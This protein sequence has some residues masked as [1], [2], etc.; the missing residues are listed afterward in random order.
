VVVAHRPGAKQTP[1]RR[2]RSRPAD[3][4]PYRF[5]AAFDVF[6]R[7][8]EQNQLWLYYTGLPGFDSVRADPRFAALVQSL[9]LPSEAGR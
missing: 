2:R 1:Q 6:K 9:G 8:E 5:D 3:R 4:K 7:A